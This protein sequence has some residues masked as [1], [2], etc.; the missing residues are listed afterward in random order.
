MVSGGLRRA[1]WPGVA[2]S[3]LVAVGVLI[4]PMS[5]GAQQDGEERLSQARRELERIGEELDEAASQVEDRERALD[6]AEKRL[7][8]IEDVVNRV[9]LQV[10]R[11]RAAVGEAEQELE[12]VEAEADELE[13]L[14]AERIAHLYMQGPELSLETFL[15][16]SGADE[17]IARTVLLER[18]AEGDQVDI[19]RLEASA[20]RVQAQRERLAEEEER[21]SGLLAEQEVL[22]AEA[23]ELRDSRAL[24]TASAR[25]RAQRLATEQ[26]DLEAEESEL[27]AL[28]ERQ[29]EEHRRQ[30]EARRRREDAQQRASRSTGAGRVSSGG[31]AWPMCAPV[32]SGYGPRWGRMHRGIDL[33]A[34][35]GTPMS[36]IRG[37]TV[38]YA[39]WRG[40]YG[41]LLLID[42]HNG[43]VSAY[44]HTSRFA[45]GAGASVSRG[46][47]VAYVG[48]TGNVTGPHLHLET[49]VNGSA[50]NP[51]QFLSGSPC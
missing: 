40:G 22:L 48:S 16:S 3:C 9:S 17:A 49:R 50:V 41:R 12:T 8:E 32:T 36:A 20:T 46:Q 21:L 2:L 34:S 27:Q 38:I 44:A 10:E 15:S 43:V 18:V 37:G 51:R 31:F 14:F 5:A 26:D 28:I 7:A 13:A 25:Q 4:A 33:G 6:D 24:A 19:E 11:Q 45:V 1:R 29:K 47:T 42:H 30:E 35:T 23:E 39:G